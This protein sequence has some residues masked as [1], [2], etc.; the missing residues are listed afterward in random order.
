M[1]L[2]P[3]MCYQREFLGSGMFNAGPAG[4]LF[5]AAPLI[6]LRGFPEVGVCSDH[7]FWLSACAR[8]GVVLVPADLFWYR[9]HAGQELRSPKAARDYA[10]VPGHAWRALNSPDCPLEGADREQAKR[11]LTWSI[12]RQTWHDLRARRWRL[13]VVR[14]QHAGLSWR[15]WLRYCRRARRSVQAGTPLDD[16]GDF[17]VPDWCRGRLPANSPDRELEQDEIET[18]R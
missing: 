10:T 1:L 3:R 14:L 13:A 5:R 15:D 12:A 2:T 7:V 4:A 8:Y 16:R 17:V 6:E 9:V 18:T 11:N